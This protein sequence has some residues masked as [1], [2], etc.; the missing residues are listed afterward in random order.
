[1][2]PLSPNGSVTHEAGLFLDFLSLCPR[3]ADVQ[4]A[5][6]GHGKYNLRTMRIEYTIANRVVRDR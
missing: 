2:P 5:L 1:M 4:F 6:V 3:I